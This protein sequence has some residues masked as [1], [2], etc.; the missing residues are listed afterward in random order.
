V[1]VLATLKDGASAPAFP[2]PSEVGTERDRK[3]HQHFMACY[4]RFSVQV[5]GAEHHP[6]ILLLN[7]ALPE[8]IDSVHRNTLT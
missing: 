4:P 1:D 2:S 3:L 5:M 7:M 8:G 6:L